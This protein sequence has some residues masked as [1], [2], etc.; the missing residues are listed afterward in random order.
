LFSSDLGFSDLKK[1][2]F[3]LF[4]QLANQA[5]CFVLKRPESG[6]FVQE[7]AEKIINLLN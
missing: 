5:R 4:T 6:N 2:H 7:V 3:M 1:E